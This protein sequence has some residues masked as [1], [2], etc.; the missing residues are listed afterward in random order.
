MTNDFHVLSLSQYQLWNRFYIQLDID[1][2]FVFCGTFG[3]VN[4]C[5][6]GNIFHLK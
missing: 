5:D 4:T 2:R 6:L 3:D 1:T